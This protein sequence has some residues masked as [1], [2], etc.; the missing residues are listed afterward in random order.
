MYVLDE[1]SIGLHQ[2][3][4]ARLLATL[5]HLRDLGNTVIVVEHDEE[6]INSADHVLDMGPGAGEHGGQVVAEGPPAEI[7]KNPASLTGQ[8]L[9]GALEIALPET[10]RRFDK[11]R[12]VR[13]RGARGNNLKNIDLALPVGLFVCVP[14]VSGSGKSTLIND[15]LYHAVAREL[16]GSAHEPAAHASIKG[17][18]FLHQPAGETQDPV[19]RPP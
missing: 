10:R 3:D 7:R 1:P 6:A 8:Y 15:T 18:A 17:L 2:R 5:K 16:Y 9:S 4:N 13:L 19:C 11:T 14:G 12:G